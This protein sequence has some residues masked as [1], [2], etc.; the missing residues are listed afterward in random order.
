M[1]ETGHVLCLRCDAVKREF[2][3]M[4]DVSRHGVRFRGHQ[5]V[6]RRYGWL[7]ING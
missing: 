7:A 1:D 4:N 5:A 3:T 2:P 6:P